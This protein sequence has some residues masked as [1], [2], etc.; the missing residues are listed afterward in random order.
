MTLESGLQ[1]NR[2]AYER[3]PSSAVTFCWGIFRKQQSATR[4]T[5]PLRARPSAS[6]QGKA[7]ATEQ[8]REAYTLLEKVPRQTGLVEGT[9]NLGRFTGI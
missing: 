4:K 7:A 9:L 8:K 2:S 6:A 3:L 5:V 1:G